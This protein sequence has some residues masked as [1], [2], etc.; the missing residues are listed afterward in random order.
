MAEYTLSSITAQIASHL[1]KE[2][3]EP[4]KRLLADKVD[5]WR[6][7]ILRNTLQ[8]K[9][10]E[11]K[12]F[13]QTIWIPLTQQSS[14]PACVTAPVCK[15]ARSAEKIPAPFRYSTTYYDFIGSVDGSEG[16][17]QKTPGMGEYQ[18]AGKYSGK[19]ILYE[20]LN[21]YLQI[22]SAINLPM[23]R[24]D[25]VFDKPGDAMRFNCEQAATGC[26]YWNEPY[27]ITGDVL[28]IVVQSILNID[29]NRVVVPTN[30]ESLVTTQSDN[31]A[32][33]G[34]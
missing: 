22:E 8:E 29:Y 25:A 18:T 26:D 6:G 11:S 28:Q 10:L 13:K 24:I 30:K 32:P 16:F 31:N 21:G 19:N 20:V 7:R 34:R 3:D 33:D 15:V 12:F 14:V 23:A 2:L 9:P 5:M 27:P 1:K 17:V 4:F